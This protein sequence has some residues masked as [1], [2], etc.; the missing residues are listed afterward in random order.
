LFGTFGC[1]HNAVLTISAISGTTITRV[2]YPLEVGAA[3][4]R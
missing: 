2:R 3:R 1:D 4:D